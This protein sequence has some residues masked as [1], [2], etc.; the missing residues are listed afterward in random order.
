[1]Q[2]LMRGRS[3]PVLLMLLFV[4]AAGAWTWP[5]Q[6][7]V[8]QTFSFDRAH[9]Y[10][11]GQHR[12]VAIGAGEGVAVLAPASGVVTFAGT[13]PTSGKTITIETPSGLAVSLTHLGSI[14]VARNANVDEGATVGTVGA[15]GTPEFDVPYVHLGVREAANDQGYLDP[16]AFLPV[17]A[18]PA[19]APAP[20]P[21]PPVTA[22]AAAPVVPAPQPVQAPAVPIA[23]PVQP[24]NPVVA[25]A[26]PVVP[27]APAVESPAP[28]P[29]EPVGPSLPEVPA[30]SAPVLSPAPAAMSPPPALSTASPVAGSGAGA[31]EPAAA[32]LPAFAPVAPA[33]EPRSFA[34]SSPAVSSLFGSLRLADV[35]HPA[36]LLAP[37]PLPPAQRVSSREGPAPG[38]AL[39]RVRALVLAASLLAAAAFLWFRRR[40]PPA[41]L[42]RLRAVASADRGQLAA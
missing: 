42:V 26:A 23:A 8:L 31:S 14:D 18:P 2:R 30:A 21:A 41:P 28:A 13:V 11:A 20:A 39:A 7:P 12:G 36:A 27:A 17:L 40:R 6:G 1:V 34:V 38:P 19:A 9:P 22:P 32:A 24:A 25:P 5:V 3:L 16:L 35:R 10:A 15:S 37:R 29:S 4:L 33:A